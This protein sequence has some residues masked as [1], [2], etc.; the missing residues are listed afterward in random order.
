MFPIY[1]YVEKEKETDLLI[2]LGAT[3]PDTDILKFKA[4]DKRKKVIKYICGNNYFNDALSSMFKRSPETG[5]NQELDEV[6]FVPQQDVLNREY[7]RILHNVP[8]DKVR[9]VPFVWDPIFLDAL[10]AKY[11]GH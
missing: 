5:Y 4:N 11:T 7:Y 1:N 3:F 2:M 9:P 10:S 6:W 8:A